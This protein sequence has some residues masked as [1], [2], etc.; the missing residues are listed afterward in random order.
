LLG[1]HQ[2]AQAAAAP[3]A[4]RRGRGIER[5]RLAILDL[6]GEACFD[7]GERDRRR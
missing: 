1:Q 4:Q 6:A 2:R 3:R 7:L 5:H